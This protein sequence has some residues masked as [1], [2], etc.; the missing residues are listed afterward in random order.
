MNQTNINKKISTL[1]IWSSNLHENRLT[2]GQTMHVRIPGLDLT[3]EKKREMV[4]KEI[5]YNKPEVLVLP[6]GASCTRGY[7][8][9]APGANKREQNINPIK[10]KNTARYQQTKVK[11]NYRED[12][13]HIKKNITEKHL[14]R[15]YVVTPKEYIKSVEALLKQYKHKTNTE[16]TVKKVVLGTPLP[17]G[18]DT[19]EYRVGKELF[20]TGL[21]REENRNKITV[22]GKNIELRVVDT[23]EYYKDKCTPEKLKELQYP[24]KVHYETEYISGFVEWFETEIPL[25]SY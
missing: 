17:W 18:L 2:N 23:Y 9:A 3:S 24:D 14:K 19:P 20:A 8:G 11:G 1:Y 5:F 15:T 13:T 4:Y 12:L 10:I 22:N 16:L 25:I 21:K 6:S 7:F